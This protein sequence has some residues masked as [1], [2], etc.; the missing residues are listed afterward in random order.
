MR[1]LVQ[2]QNFILLEEEQL[3]YMKPTRVTWICKVSEGYSFQL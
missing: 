3:L 2:L 1:V